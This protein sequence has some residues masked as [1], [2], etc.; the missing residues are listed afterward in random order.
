MIVQ[1]VFLESRS[2]SPDCSAIKRSLLVNGT[3][4]TLLASPKVAAATARH[5]ST[6][7]PF[8]LPAESVDENPT[9]PVDTPQFKV[10]LA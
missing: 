3:N 10:P 9:K 5:I 1:V 2:I 6:S 7:S 8:H 4:F